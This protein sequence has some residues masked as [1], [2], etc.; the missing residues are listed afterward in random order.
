MFVKRHCN[1]NREECQGKSPV[2]FTLEVVST[3]PRAFIVR[4]YFTN[5]EADEIMRIAL[6]KL[7]QSYVGN[8]DD[9]GG[10]VSETRTSRNAWLPR[11]ASEIINTI[12]HR[13]ADLLN[14]D[15]KLMETNK[16]VEE[17]QVVRY[18]QGQRYDSHHDWGVSGFPESRYIT[19]LL[20]L[21][22]MP[23]G[24]GGETSFPKGGPNGEGIKIIPK[25]GDAAV[26]YNLLQDGNGDDLSLHAAM[27]V[28]HG[29]KWLANFWV[30][31][32]K[33]R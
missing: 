22:D 13:T 29:T 10:R 19:V 20:Y 12:F 15:E 30:W 23:E 33:R 17:M 25:K 28:H 32:P 26:F 3:K 4:N 16:N 2:E 6:S 31:D 18:N 24:A 5:Q 14:I 7:D 1:G 11:R 9:G 27:P 21:N 8:K